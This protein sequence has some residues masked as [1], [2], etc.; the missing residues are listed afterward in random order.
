MTLV[1][2]WRNE[3]PTPS[4]WMATD[5]RISDSSVRLIDEGIKL[6][7]VPVVCTKAG[8]SGFFDTPFFATSIGLAGAGLSLV[9]Q[10][11]YGTLVPVLRS[12]TCRG[13]SVPSVAAIAAL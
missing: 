12:L 3:E 7:E 5:S 13:E 9:F 1:A 10:H 8:S 11:V 4:L 6:Y 2:V